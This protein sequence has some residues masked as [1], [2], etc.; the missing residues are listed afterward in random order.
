MKLQIFETT[1]TG[2]KSRA[3]AGIQQHFV[4]ALCIV[5]PPFSFHFYSSDTEAMWITKLQKD[6]LL[7]HISNFAQDP[8]FL[9]LWRAHR[10]NTFHLAQHLP[11]IQVKITSMATKEVGSVN[12]QWSG[13]SYHSL[14]S[15][16]DL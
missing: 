13:R 11:L 3:V 16:F 7:M 15:D 12:Q 4:Y 14:E 8:L 10:I 2:S 9:L 1:P 5:L 6:A